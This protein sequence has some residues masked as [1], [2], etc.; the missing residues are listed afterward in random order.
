MITEYAIAVDLGQ[1]RD[2]I[3]LSIIGFDP[4]GLDARKRAIGNELYNI[5]WLEHYPKGTQYGKMV[6]VCKRHL[7]HPTLEGRTKLLVD[8][9]EVGKA[10]IEQFQEAGLEPIGIQLTAGNEPSRSVY[11]FNVPKKDVVFAAV[12]AYSQARVVM[13]QAEPGTP[14][15]DAASKLDGELGKFVIKA[16]KHSMSLGF[17]AESAEDHDDLVMSVAMGIWYLREYGERYDQLEE[18]AVKEWDSLRNGL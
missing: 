7:Q 13:Y 12:A 3:A 14:A 15:A 16:K 10:V 4:G 2:H 5:L 8:R 9:G 1:V 18:Q 11:G 17:E 6:D